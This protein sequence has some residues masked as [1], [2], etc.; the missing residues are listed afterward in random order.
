MINESHLHPRKV[1]SPVFF[2]VCN[3]FL[4]E[5]LEVFGEAAIVFNYSLNYI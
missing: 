1:V 2:S 3:L 4:L 5:I